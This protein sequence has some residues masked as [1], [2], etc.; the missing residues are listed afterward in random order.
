MS[1]WLRAYY[2]CARQR[3]AAPMSDASSGM[4]ALFGACYESGTIALIAGHKV[5][6][7]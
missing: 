2:T 5:P 3:H 4:C 6:L 7:C 1:A